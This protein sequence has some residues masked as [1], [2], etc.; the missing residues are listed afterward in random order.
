[1]LKV[2]K[3]LMKMENNNVTAMQFNGWNFGHLCDWMHG[4]KGT[5]PAEYTED[6][7]I[8]DCLIKRN[9]WVVKVNDKEFVIMTNTEFQNKYC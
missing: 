6:C 2:Y 4:C 7:V 3:L 8:A 9:D 1:M 5:Y